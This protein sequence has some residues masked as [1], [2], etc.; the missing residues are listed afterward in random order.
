MGINSLSFT[1]VMKRLVPVALLALAGGIAGC[2]S[3]DDDAAGSLVDDA[4]ADVP[5]GQ[6]PG[7]APPSGPSGVDPAPGTS[8]PPPVTATGDGPGPA[9]RTLAA[10]ES[11]GPPLTDDP[12]EAGIHLRRFDA[13][14]DA[15]EA[16]AALSE[17]G[18]EDSSDRTNAADVLERE[19][20]TLLGLYLGRQD[21]LGPYDAT[22]TGV[23]D[24]GDR[25]VVAVDTTYGGPCYGDDALGS[26][27]RLVHV[28]ASA[29]T[30]VFREAL[31][32]CED[33]RG[34]SRPDEVRDVAV[35]F[36][37]DASAVLTWSAPAN[38]GP[39]TRYD[40]VDESGEYR[41]F[42]GVGAPRYEVD[43]LVPGLVRAYRIVPVDPDL[44]DA[45]R[46]VPVGLVVDAP[47]ALFRGRVR[48]EDFVARVAALAGD[49]AVDCGDAESPTGI[50]SAPDAG[51][52]A[53]GC[54]DRAL[55][56]GLAFRRT[57]T[58]LVGEA[59]FARALV[60]D[61]AGDVRR[62]DFALSDVDLG[63]AFAPSVDFGGQ[64]L[65][66]PCP[67]PIVD[68]ANGRVRCD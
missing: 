4:P 50:F 62:L 59:A 19:G 24:E 31:V 52:S 27:F 10:G 42:D 17:L 57:W 14:T 20:G 48:A 25:L 47:S 23:A 60:G 55:A 61:D 33:D 43:G 38:G 18:W 66:T 54:V 58:F 67:V 11:G 15:A 40:V 22:V 13:Y 51:E 5:E 68:D 3:D 32:P 36:V 37:D 28:A 1:A 53:A 30:A 26:P 41:T 8:E 44:D 12:D 7:T 49:G 64:L 56:E 35:E 2:A 29:P 16:R 65:G 39:G 46:G 6:A 45:P 63:N 21:S 9:F 34:S